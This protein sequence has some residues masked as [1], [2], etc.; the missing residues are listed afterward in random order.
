MKHDNVN[1]VGLVIFALKYANQAMELGE[2]LA[3]PFT[4][5]NDDF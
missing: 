3:L 4:E 1:Y 2:G 5:L